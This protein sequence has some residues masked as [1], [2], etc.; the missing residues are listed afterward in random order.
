MQQKNSIE[1]ADIHT[2]ILQKID[3]G[4]QSLEEAIALLKSEKEQGISHI[5][6]TPHFQLS[7]ISLESFLSERKRLFSELLEKLEESGLGQDIKL[8]LGAE[9]RYDPNL[10]YTDIYKLCI[11]NT[12]YILLELPV[13][14]PFN[15]E[16][17]ILW[18][19]SQGITPIIAHVERYSWLHDNFKL[20]KQ[21]LK[22][23]VVFQCNSSSLFIKPYVKI[24]KKL[25]RR[26]Y[27]QLLA[28]DTHNV[29]NRP[30]TLEQGLNTLK[31]KREELIKNSLCVVEDKNIVS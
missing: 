31:F 24:V 14:Y 3:D 26:G 16:Q 6:L 28:S 27:V 13:A 20:L 19:I 30:P 21:L 23:G 12:S 10:V 4:A 8:H 25:A 11:E 18:M 29:D 1:I 7:D 2:H 15:F 9:V 5:V 17:T 22:E